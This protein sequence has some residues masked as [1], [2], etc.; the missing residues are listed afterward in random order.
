MSNV[1]IRIA[2]VLKKEYIDI[3]KNCII[4]EDKETF[5]SCCMNMGTLF[6][7]VRTLPKNE[8]FRNTYFSDL[9]D[10]K[11]L[12]KEGIYPIDAFRGQQS[13]TSKICYFVNPSGYRLMYDT[14]VSKFLI[15]FK[16][17]HPDFTKIE[18][19]TNHKDILIKNWVTV[20]KNYFDYMH[21]EY[22]D[23]DVDTEIWNG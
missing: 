8:V 4:N 18:F 19:N 12:I 15:N 1:D 5:K 7:A 23:I 17:D 10:K 3:M 13:L 9:W 14:R 21:A 16:K 20:T 11:E 2:N 6:S 22:D